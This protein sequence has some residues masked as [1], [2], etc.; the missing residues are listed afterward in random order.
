MRQS[1]TASTDPTPFPRVSIVGVGCRATGAA[2]D[3]DWFGIGEVEAAGMDPRQRVTLEVAIEALDDSGLGCLARGSYAAVVFGAA[4]VFGTGAPNGA[5]QLSRALDLHGPSL[6]V[7]SDRAS[8][9]VAVDTA[10]RL[11]ADESVPF[12][13]AGGVDLALLPDISGITLPADTG[14]C[15]VL[16]LQ[17]TSDALRTG[18]HRYAEITGT[19]LGFPGAGKHDP[20]IDLEADTAPQGTSAERGNQPPTLLALSGRDLTAVHD[21]A[22]YW[23]DS[24]TTYHSLAEFAAATARLTT[25]PIRAAILAHDTT[26]AHTQLSILANRIATDHPAPSRSVGF[27][28]ATSGEVIG[29]AEEARGGGVLWLFSGSGGH[30]RMGRALAARYPAFSAAL[31]D[32]A[33]AVVE[34]GGPRVWTPRNGFGTCGPGEDFAQPALFA[35]QWALAGLLTA[36]GVRADGMAGYGVGEVAAAAVGRAVSLP[37]AARIVV[38]RGRLLEK[39]VD[40][41][42][43]AVLEATVA[44]AARLLEPMRAEV[45][46]AA[47]D[48]PR[49]ITVSGE[50]RY[51]DALIR[52]AHRRAIFAQRV[53]PDEVIGG[54]IM[55]PHVPRVRSIAS[56]LI[57]ELSGIEPLTPE[58]TIYSTTRRGA[59]LPSAATVAETRSAAAADIRPGGELRMDAAY[60][61]ANAAGPVELGAALEQAAAAGISTVLEVGPHAALGTIVRAHTRFRGSTYSTGSRTDEAAALLRVLG[62]L[63]VEGRDID[64]TAMGPR[65]AAPPQRHW[66][67]AYSGHGA[68]LPPAA[69]RPEGTYVVAG[70]LGSSGAIAVRWLLDSGARDVVVLTR[71]PRALPPPLDGMEDWIV[72][73][74][75]DAS[76]RDDLATALHDIRE[77]GSPIRGVV[78]AG[79]ERD[80]GA[81]ANLAAL[82]AADPTDFSIGFSTTGWQPLS[83]VSSGNDLFARE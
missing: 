2:F 44:E 22:R 8:P 28:T 45:G 21:L 33:D 4:A 72:L 43:A 48:G 77:C 60:W 76:D 61:G 37:D 49:S 26:D 80:P 64:F 34:A 65:T 70:G 74:R 6:L 51:I 39:V 67:R 58:A 41:G 3:R 68:Q 24:L 46:I 56:Q 27:R 5:H 62:R 47:V 19:G 36:W 78:H 32:A 25:E 79:R 13:L 23:A 57:Q 71:Q 54:T 7:Q 63:H 81:A 53:T 15:T 55:V 73:V 10:M 16:V 9:L 83:R 52:R 1:T 38:A 35:F 50:S 31:M 30:A 59:V 82:T 11:L 29:V 66:R 40:H 20:H 18:T 42:A 75:C 12:V 14:R 17:R 69:I